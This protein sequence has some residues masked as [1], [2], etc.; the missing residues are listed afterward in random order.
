M[1]S[2]LFICTAN[3]F[4]SPLAA[5]CFLKAIEQERAAETWV[6]ESAGTWTKDG[7]P[8]A[9]ITLQV[10]RQLGVHGLHGHRTRQ[11]SQNLLN[12][13]NLII[14]ME[15]GHKESISIEFPSMRPRLYLLSEIVDSIA[16]DI[17]DPGEHGIHAGE[18]GRELCLLLNRG[19]EKILQLARS[20]SN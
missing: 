4:R 15:R 3:Q 10:A 14:V 11:I 17:P 19:K 7:M 16:Y 18:I 2:I 13:Y 1:P 20:L 5:A 12:Q 6:V 8:A 9:E